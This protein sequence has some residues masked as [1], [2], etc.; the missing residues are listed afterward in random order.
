MQHNAI[1]YGY[2]CDTSAVLKTNKKH[3]QKC[4]HILPNTVHFYSLKNVKKRVV[5]LALS[6]CTEE[7]LENTKKKTQTTHPE[8]ICAIR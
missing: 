2:G 4:L 5:E 1:H 3:T 8:T 6:L 7:L